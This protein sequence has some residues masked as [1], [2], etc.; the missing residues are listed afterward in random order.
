MT[1]RR[2]LPLEAA[3]ALA[4]QHYRELLSIRA[5]DC[6]ADGDFGNGAQR[7]RVEALL[8]KLNALIV[9]IQGA[10]SER[11]RSDETPIMSLVPSHAHFLRAELLPHARIIQKASFTAD[12]LA[13]LFDL[14]EDES[15]DSSHTI[16]N[17]LW[18]TTD[19][20]DNLLDDQDE[21]RL[22]VDIAQETL[23]QQWFQP[24]F[25]SSNLR[26]LRP[27][28][29][30]KSESA[31]PTRIKVRLAE[32]QKAFVFGAWMATIALSRAII[33]FAL[34]ERAQ[35][36]GVSPVRKTS[37]GTQRYL[38]LDDLIKTVS[39]SHPEL[40]RGL[41]VLQDAGNR[42][43]HPKKKQNVIPTPKVLRSEAYE[44]VKETLSLVE[45]LYAK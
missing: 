2:P 6:L 27:A 38:K 45:T 25:W 36:F 31:I 7:L 12:G 21:R 26:M 24:D 39:K 34:I 17:A 37:D 9:Q 18:F 35:S 41:R 15:V 10:L 16:R 14:L 32:M 29:L 22:S 19:Y 11:I 4:E 43:L 8:D 28:L 44:C 42:V 40:E 33:E 30:G 13:D 5:I 20:A 3:I 1:S 23:E